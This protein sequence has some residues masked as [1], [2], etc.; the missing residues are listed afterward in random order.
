MR[1]GDSSA[2]AFSP[3]HDRARS[4]NSTGFASEPEGYGFDILPGEVVSLVE[5]QVRCAYICRAQ[6]VAEHGT[7]YITN[8]RLVFA[9]YMNEG[10][11]VS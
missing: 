6:D 1:F 9:A 5:E 7:L 8:Y 4:T 2:G 3:R 10:V 11:Q